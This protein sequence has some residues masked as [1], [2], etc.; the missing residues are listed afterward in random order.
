VRPSATGGVVQYDT[1]FT[2]GSEDDGDAGSIVFTTVGPSVVTA[3]AAPTGVTKATATTHSTVDANS[4]VPISETRIEYSTDPDFDPANVSSVPGDPATLPGEPGD[5][6]VTGSL[7]GLAAGTVYYYRI[8]ATNGTMTTAGKIESFQTP[9]S[10]TGINPPGGP[11][12][13]GTKVTITGTGF[14]SGT[15]VTVGGVVCT[16]SR[17]CRPPG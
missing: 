15:S 6:P 13:G 16:P 14:R 12:A 2:G 7:S 10:V 17:S 4:D 9:I 1:Q 3:A 11:T 5:K 8:V